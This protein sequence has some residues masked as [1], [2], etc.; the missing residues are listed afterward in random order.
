MGLQPPVLWGTSFHTRPAMSANL[1]L[2]QCQSCVS[3][4]SSP[5]LS[6]E[7]IPESCP[8]RH[9]GLGQPSLPPYNWHCHQR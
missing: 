3:R 8:N 5:C 7:T 1:L 2:W 4:A 9:R 6:C